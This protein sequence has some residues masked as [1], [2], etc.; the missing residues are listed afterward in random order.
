MGNH[1]Q[2]TLRMPERFNL[3]QRLEM[4]MIRFEDTFGLNSDESSKNHVFWHKMIGTPRSS[5]KRSFKASRIVSHRFCESQF[6]WQF[7]FLCV[8][9]AKLIM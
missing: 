5:S 3:K 4:N 6:P 8:N 9:D 1:I 7:L 2:D